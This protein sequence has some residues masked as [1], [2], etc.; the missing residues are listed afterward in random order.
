MCSSR[1]IMP[2]PARNGS[3]LHACDA[4]VIFVKKIPKILAFFFEISLSFSFHRRRDEASFLAVQLATVAS[5]LF[6]AI[7]S[8]FTGFLI[9]KTYI[10]G[11]WIWFYY[12]CPGAP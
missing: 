3:C 1:L 5:S 9:T 6:Y 12:L 11:W 8:L 7:W 2:A 10:E 4:L